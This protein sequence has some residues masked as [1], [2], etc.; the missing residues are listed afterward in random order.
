MLV[1]PIPLFGSLV[2]GFL[3]DV[4]TGEG[5]VDLV[6][7]I[8]IAGSAIGV[9]KGTAGIMVEDQIGRTVASS[10]EL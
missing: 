7:T 8:V 6:Q 9:A 4:R 5:H 3:G 10:L 1:L 2:L